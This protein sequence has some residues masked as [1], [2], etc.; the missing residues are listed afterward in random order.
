M[1]K[2]KQLLFLLLLAFLLRLPFLVFRSEPSGDEL[3]YLA[4]S[5]RVFNL[6][7]LRGYLH[8]VDYDKV[9]FIGVLSPFS[10][11]VYALSG[12]LTLSASL[13][14]FILSL[15]FVWLFYNFTSRLYGKDTA[16]WAGFL[17]AALPSV[18]Y[19]SAYSLTNPFYAFF[20]V[21]GS[22][23]LWRY[24]NQWKTT[25]LVICFL[26][27]ISLGK[28]RIEGLGILFF[29]VY[30]VF[31]AYHRKEGEKR[32]Y[33]KITAVIFVSTV[34]LFTFYRLLA[35]RIFGI[36][37]LSSYSALLGKSLG[38]LTL[39]L[40][41]LMNVSTPGGFLQGDKLSYLAH[42]PHLVFYAGLSIAYDVLKTLFIIPGRLFPPLLF[43][44]LG[45]VFF[46]REHQADEPVRSLERFFLLSLLTILIYPV[47]WFS[48]SRFAYL[49][50]PVLLFFLAK[51]VEFY[52]S[53]LAHRLGGAQFR[54]RVRLVLGLGILAYL[55]FFLVQ[56]IIPQVK[57]KQATDPLKPVAEWLITEFGDEEV[58]VLSWSE[59]GSRINKEQLNFPIKV[60][61]VR[62]QWREM[63]VSLDETLKMLQAR[64]NTLLVLSHQEVF[65]APQGAGDYFEKSAA[66]NLPFI[67]DE[68]IENMRDRSY[69]DSPYYL[70][71]F[72]ALLDGTL[73]V[74]GLSLL[75][76][77]ETGPGGDTYYIFFCC[78]SDN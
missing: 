49:L 23:F 15:L 50:V 27:L 16:F 7:A 4:E 52:E 48:C 34:L 31:A 59:L 70:Q 29:G 62:G 20:F 67:N 56:L 8:L 33:L 66:I 32:G 71:E 35:L 3:R 43:L 10:S 76:V 22:F 75:K 14:P 68:S 55:T 53:A 63:P 26:I 18:V 47:F 65:G 40:N 58:A 11:L 13:F 12:D 61:N 42:N 25:D 2:D 69:R 38:Y 60:E 28:I 37:P 44:F 6:E 30:T 24:L 78:R 73:E 17:C 54:W 46:Q 74:K 5:F 45:Y 1:F 36:S 9:F 41:S 64:G 39:K 72:K 19:Y 21:L 57:H 51:G 77:I